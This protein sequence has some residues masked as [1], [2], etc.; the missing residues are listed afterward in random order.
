M[1]I[2]TEVY[3]DGVVDVTDPCTLNT[4]KLDTKGIF[5]AIQYTNIYGVCVYNNNI[6]YAES[7]MFLTFA[8]EYDADE[9]MECNGANLFTKVWDENLTGWIV[10]QKK[11]R[12]VHVNYFVCYYLGNE[13]CY[14][15][16]QG[17][18]PYIQ[19]AKVFDKKEA[20]KLAGI[21]RAKTK[22]GKCWIAERVEME[23]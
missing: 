13:V 6:E 20:N 16:E 19:C 11:C 17:Y 15:A 5:E 18:T 8:D 9:Y 10:L 7:Y 1:L 12:I 21:L 2:V 22:T 4:S 23:H 3:D 14:V